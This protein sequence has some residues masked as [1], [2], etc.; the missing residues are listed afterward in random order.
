M[1]AAN[2]FK[3]SLPSP[4]T[5]TLIGTS[6]ASVGIVAASADKF[7]AAENQASMANNRNP[8][9]KWNTCIITL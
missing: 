9:Q 1:Q 8:I 3:N 4:G 2:K 6:A 5:L 7:E